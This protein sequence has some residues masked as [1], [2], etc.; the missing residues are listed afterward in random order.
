MRPKLEFEETE[1]TIVLDENSNGRHTITVNKEYLYG[2]TIP[3]VT[4]QYTPPLRVP[5]FSLVGNIDNKITRYSKSYYEH[6]K[7]FYFC[8][9]RFGIVT[10]ANN[11]RTIFFLLTR[12]LQNSVLKMQQ[13][14]NLFQLK[15]IQKVMQLIVF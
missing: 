4:E 9:E 5:G 8:S 7:L 12:N 15:F 2:G 1:K 6:V 13:M 3:Q 10:T 14:V 11:P